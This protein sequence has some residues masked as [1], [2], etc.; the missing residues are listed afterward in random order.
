MPPQGPPTWTLRLKYHKTTV[1]V[2][3]KPQ[4]H[5]DHVVSELHRALRETHR[6]GRL[7]TATGS[8]TIPT[9][10]GEIQLAKPINT[11][12]H[13]QGWTKIYAATEAEDGV[14][15]GDQTT[16]TA[17]RRRSN[18]DASQSLKDAGL[19]DGSVLAFRFANQLP[20]DDEALGLEEAEEKWD[21]VIAA[22][23]DSTGVVNTGDVGEREH[24]KG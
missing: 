6:D 20:D 16:N 15:E 21:V 10:A 1:V 7:Q 2:D 13:T 17:K 5:V 12:D 24:Y 8:V 22:Y 19:K 9:H 23:E 4:D 11:H 3:A 18:N 14:D